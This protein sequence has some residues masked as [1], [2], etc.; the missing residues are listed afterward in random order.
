MGSEL[1]LND[2]GLA[3]LAKAG[4]IPEGTPIDILRVFVAACEQHGLSP[5]KKEIY[6]VKYGGNYNTIVGIDGLRAKACRTG[7]YAGREESKYNLQPDGQYLTAAQLTRANQ[8][9]TT[10][11]VTVMRIVQ[12]HICRFTKTVNF[13]EYC[14]RNPT[15]KWATMPINQIDKCAEAAALR[16]AFADQTSGLNIYE[17]GAAIE[18]AT[19]QAAKVEPTIR[20]TVENARSE[21]LLMLERAGALL[22]DDYD[23]VEAEIRGTDDIDAIRINYR[24]L[25]DLLRDNPTDP[26]KQFKNFAKQL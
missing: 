17:E 10:C 2:T 25:R 3:T 21:T 20:M 12:G 6:L 5:M 24:K 4:V 19:I 14:P 16:M 8:L 9:P 15:N 22:G 7:A 11:T 1:V 23:N 26:A 13:D 18:D